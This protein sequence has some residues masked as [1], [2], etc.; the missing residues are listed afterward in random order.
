VRRRPS[1]ALQRSEVPRAEAP[2][3]EAARGHPAARGGEHQNIVRTS[4]LLT[5]LAG[6]AAQGLRLTDVGRL[7]GLGKAT[8]HRLLAGLVAHGLAE[9]DES[10]RFFLGKRV[11]S[12]AAA[13]AN[14]FG[15]ARLATPLLAEIAQKF[16]DTVYLSLRS[17]DEAVCI[18]RFEGAFPIK[19]L[20]LALG[21]SR[22]LGTGAGSLAI[23][24]ALPPDEI[25]RILV[26]QR[27]ARAAY[28]FD[29]PTLRHL[30]ARAQR[31]GYALNDGGIEPAM[32]AVGVALHA[33]A[34][35]VGAVSVAAIA[36]RLAP[37]RREAVV[38]ALRDAAAAIERG[39]GAE[40]PRGAPP[41][42]GPGRPADAKR[43]QQR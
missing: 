21:E 17:G 32:S 3:A 22:P 15:L 1:R 28:G 37:P 42:R 24:A 11:L 19:T 31:Q 13:A 33:P 26:A 23:L 40:P 29:E 5:A 18:G 6:A 39:L 25:E 36:D 10:G 7:T 27:A 8:A 9:Q 35:V 30:V 16:E 14:R 12:L 38:A 34:G 4:L 41:Q 20:T 2:R 43:R